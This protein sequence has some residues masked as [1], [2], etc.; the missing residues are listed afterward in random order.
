MEG[1]RQRSRC[2][3]E[4]G[5]RRCGRRRFRHVLLRRRRGGSPGSGRSHHADRRI[6]HEALGR[7]ARYGEAQSLTSRQGRHPVRGPHRLQRRF[8]RLFPRPAQSRGAADLRPP[9]RQR[10]DHGQGLAGGYLAHHVRHGGHVPE[11]P[12]PGDHRPAVEHD[13]RRSEDDG[14]TS[15]SSA[16]TPASSGPSGVPG[17]NPSISWPTAKSSSRTVGSRR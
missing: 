6:R 7:R 3:P 2:V 5:H 4:R 9:V 15:S 16:R 11:A 10:R 12:R 14:G 13:P 1:H 17:R 8:L